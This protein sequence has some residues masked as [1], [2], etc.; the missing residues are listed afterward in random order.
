MIENDL[1]KAAKLYE[2]ANLVTLA[3]ECFES[4]GEW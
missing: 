3:I 2:K 4:G 1:S